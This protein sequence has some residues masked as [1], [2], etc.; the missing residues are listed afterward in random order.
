MSMKPNPSI[1]MRQF[2]ASDADNARARE[3]ASRALPPLLS[4]LAA[5]VSYQSRGHLLIL[6]PEDLGR[7]AAA[8]IEGLASVHLLVTAP[9][10]TQDD[11]HLEQAMAA[12]P[13][14]KPVYLPLQRL[15]GWLGQFT[16]ELKTPQGE[17]INPA[18]AMVGSAF[19][20]LVLDLNTQPVI[21]R[22]LSPPGYY[23]VAADA[24]TLASVVQELSGM[25][26]EFDKPQYVQVNHDLCAHADRGKQGCTR[27]LDVC[28]ADAI[29]SHNRTDSHDYIIEVDTHLCHGAGSCT[30]ACPTGALSFEV[31]SAA[32]QLQ[33]LQAWLDSYRQYGGERAAVLLYAEHHPLQ[34]ESLP[35]H[36][37]PLAL[38]EVATLGS[39]IWFALLTQGVTWVGLLVDAQT[40]PTLVQLLQRETRLSGQLLQALGHPAERITLLDAD[41]LPQQLAILESTL[42][43]WE[44]LQPSPP[45]QW[46]G[47]RELLN[48][49]FD[50]LH[51]QG[52]GTDAPVSLAAGSPF[53]QVLVDE[54]AC[55]LC[56]SCVALCPTAAL[57]NPQQ[58]QPLLAF[59]ESACV[60][61]G[62][63]ERSCPERAITLEARFLPAPGAR[64]QARVLKQ[65]EP[66]HCI[67]CGVAFA[68]RSTIEKITRTLEGHAYFQG[69]AARRLQMC[70]D[71]RVRDS[72]RELAADP[73]AQLRL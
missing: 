21:D 14:L 73:T 48:Q 68:S 5:A 59:N 50:C 64:E 28:P 40:P 71:C 3:Q 65:E 20:D 43:A 26:G 58:A 49:A 22:E 25:V 24:T 30:T 15:S 18:E 7:L 23:H 44:G 12:T 63:C 67:S 70:E 66:F 56:M 32:N 46:T 27:C 51:E 39:E 16:L 38:E 42:G 57:N 29:F 10:S 61:C 4:T 45:L 41:S 33:R 69:E 1:A 35:G 53:G 47:K 31:P 17:V 60:Q 36:V 13:H 52:Q 62:L 11:A 55:T 2:L 34:M 72:Y 37:L 6:G 19:F 54:D 8:Q 9:L